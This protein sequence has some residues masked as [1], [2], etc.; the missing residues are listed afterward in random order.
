MSAC[1]RSWISM[2]AIIYI[3]IR[4]SLI[5]CET[6][7]LSKCRVM[8]LRHPIRKVSPQSLSAKR[9]ACCCGR[10]V[11]LAVANTGRAECGTNWNETKAVLSESLASRHRQ[12]NKSETRKATSLR[13]SISRAPSLQYRR[14]LSRLKADPKTNDDSAANTNTITQKWDNGGFCRRTPYKGYFRWGSCAALCDQTLYL[15]V[16]NTL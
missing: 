10:V 5:K 6:N 9:G 1:N 14:V 2:R 8:M 4:T 16:K 11:L 3:Y 13:R 15:H 7:W 12:T